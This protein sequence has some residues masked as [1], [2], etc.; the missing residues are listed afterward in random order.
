MGV[1]VYVFVLRFG[2]LCFFR[3]WVF[4]SYFRGWERGRGYFICYRMFLVVEY[5]G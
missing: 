4:S 1:L 3:I 5:G 2:S